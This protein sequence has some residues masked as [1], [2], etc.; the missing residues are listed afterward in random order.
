MFCE[1]AMI[2]FVIWRQIELAEIKQKDDIG[3][4]DL[5]RLCEDDLT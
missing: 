4:I 3:E 2:D 1:Y 5:M